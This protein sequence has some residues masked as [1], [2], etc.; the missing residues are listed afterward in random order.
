MS[1]AGDYV[2]AAPIGGSEPVRLTPVFVGV[3]LC[4]VGLAP[5]PGWSASAPDGTVLP[6]P[7]KDQQEIEAMLGAGVVGTA[8]PSVP[9]TNV[10]LYFP[11][12][13]RTMTYNVTSGKNAG[14]VQ[15]LH[16]AKEQRP[17]GVTAWRFGL[18]PSLAGFLHQTAR[19]DLFM[20]AVSDSG[21]GVVVVTTPPNPFLLNGMQPGTTRTF[22]QTVA[23]NYL[24]DPTDRRYSGT[25][26]AKYTYVGTYQVTVPAGTYQAILVRLAYEGKI[27]PAHTQ[28]TAY[29][30][31]APHVGVVAMISQEDVEAFWIIHI[32]SK[33]G[34]VLASAS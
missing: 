28:D 19:G 22:K 5:T 29:Y 10:A 16:V 11:L 7:S 8:L 14:N 26:Q 9:I 32:D 1:S 25:L 31:F 15:T 23:V 3:L 13:D 30:F 20:P 18:S 17:N 21:E 24:D 6:L 34:K 12:Q 2:A 33:S 27:G 4:A